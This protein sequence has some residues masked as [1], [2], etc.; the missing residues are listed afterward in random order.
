M[1]KLVT[2]KQNFSKSHP[3]NNIVL[4]FGVL[5]KEKLYRGIDYKTFI[6]NDLNYLDSNVVHYW[7]YNKVIHEVMWSKFYSD[8]DSNYYYPLQKIMEKMDYQNDD[9]EVTPELQ[10]FHD[11]F[12]RAFTLIELNGI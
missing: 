12:T 9:L 5:D 4:L 11:E 6:K 2:S 8:S 3:N 1:V 10:L 7:H